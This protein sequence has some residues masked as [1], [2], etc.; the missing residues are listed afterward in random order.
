[1]VVPSKITHPNVKDYFK[2]IPFYN[3]PIE[4]PKILSL[5]NIDLSAELPFFEKLNI[6]KTNQAF[7]GYA[8]SYKIEII[9][10]KKKKI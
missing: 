8:M 4:K 1:M 10:K 7:S 9:E 3:R 5:K 2:E 6:I